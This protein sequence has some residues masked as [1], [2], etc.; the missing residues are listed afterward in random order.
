MASIPQV[1][2]TRKIVGRHTLSNDEVHTFQE[3]SIGMVS[4]WRKAGPVYEVPFD[5]LSSDDLQNVLFA[6]RLVSTTEQLW[7]VLRVIPCCAV[8]GEAAGTAAAMFTDF[9]NI[10]ILA[11]QKRLENQGVVLHENE[12]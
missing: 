12:L 11:L 1:R 5:V 2:M 8:T 6:G 3:R 7:D 4:D 9:D 10:D